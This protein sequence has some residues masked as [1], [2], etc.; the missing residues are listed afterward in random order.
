MEFEA[1]PINRNEDIS[2]TL[3]WLKGLNR[4]IINTENTACYICKEG[5]VSF[6]IGYED[7]PIMVQLKPGENVIIPPNTPYVDYSEKGVVMI[8]TNIKPFDMNQVEILKT[9]DVLKNRILL[10]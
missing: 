7:N 8:V 1:I 4:R 10:T 2:T 5:Y 6:F 9:S 3:I